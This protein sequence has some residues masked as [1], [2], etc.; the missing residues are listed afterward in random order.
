MSTRIKSTA[1]Y[2]HPFSK[3]YWK[4]AAAE[5]KSTKTLVI[6]ALMVA[7]RVATKGLALPI[8]PNLDLFN[9]ASFINALS[10]MIIGPVM[11]IPA[12]LLSDFLGVLL[13]DGL[14]TYFFPYAL[15]EIASSLIWALLLYRAKAT[16]W[17]VILGRFAICIFVN[18]LLGTGIN[19]WWQMV[20]YGNSTVALTIPRIIKNTF[21]FPIESVVMTFFLGLMIPITNRMGLTYTGANAKEALTFGKKQIILLVV[22]FVLGIG[23]VTGYLFYHYDTTSLSASYT[24]EER[25]EYNC[26]M[27]AIVHEQAEEYE[28][29]TTVTTIESAYKKLGKGYTTYNV[30]VYTVDETALPDSDYTLEQLRGLS[31]S[32]AAAAAKTGV[33]EK[34]A[35]A[36]I[37]VDGDGNVLEFTLNPTK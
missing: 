32:K 15:Q 22:L 1:L 5:V 35:T 16:P 21:M 33:M 2:P 3:A 28:G 4:D 7:L 10:A 11:A 37:V 23:C 24:T 26:D 13:W 20:Y 36:V 12:A 34:T 27:D 18:V 19:I 31:K 14:G 6:A 17:R 8:A 29:L 25:Y 30:A 9:L